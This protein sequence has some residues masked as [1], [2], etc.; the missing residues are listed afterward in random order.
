MLHIMLKHK[1]HS[2]T[3]KSQQLHNYSYLMWK[4]SAEYRT[5]NVSLLSNLSAKSRTRHNL[6]S[7][8]K[9]IKFSGRVHNHPY[10]LFSRKCHIKLLFRCFQNSGQ[11]L[12]QLSSMFKP[13]DSMH[14][15]YRS[16]FS[17]LAAFRS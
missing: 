15:V 4:F 2:R 9:Y 11:T 1:I 5:K 10:F 13:I 16:I 3:D 7:T 14:P 6:L 8:N 12:L 17:S